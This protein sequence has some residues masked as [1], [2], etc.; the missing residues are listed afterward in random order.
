LLLYLPVAS[1]VTIDGHI[2]PQEWAQARHITEFRK[3]VPL[4]GEAPSLATEAW[5]LATPEGL[6][7]AFHS[8]QPLSIPRTNQRVQRDF[9]AQVDRVNVFVDFEG[10]HR[11]AYEFTIS[12][13]NGVS[14]GVI[15]NEYYFNADW[16][17]NWLHATS[18]DEFGWTAEVLLP[19][20]LAPMRDAQEGKR[21]IGLCLDRVVAATGER[22]AW[23]FASFERSRFISDFAPIE[24]PGFSQSLLAVTPY[25]SN[26]YDN[27]RKDGKTE[28]GG[29]LFWKPNGQ[30]QL[31]ATLNPD[32]GQVESDDLIVNFDATET[33]ISDKRPFFTENQSIFEFTTPA[34]YSQLLYTRRIGGPADD[35]NGS[36]DITA[37][38]K[39]NGNLGAT[40]YGVFAA[41]EAGDAG[42]TFGALRLVRDFS[43]QNLGFMLTEV[44]RPYFDREATV[45]GVDQNWRPTSKWNVRTRVIGS[46][47]EQ[48]DQSYS[49]LGETMLVDYEMNDGWR[50]QWMAIHFGK[51]LEIND[52]GYLAR[53]SENYLHWQVNRRFTDLPESSRYSSKDWG[54]RISTDYNDRGE[55][56]SDQIRITRES[57]LRNGAYEY[58]NLRIHSNGVDDLLTR[59]HGSVKLPSYTTTYLEYDRPRKGN[60]LYALQAEAYGGG[61]SGNHRAGFRIEVEPTYFISD[62]FNVYVGVDASRKPDWLVWQQDNFIGSFDAREFQFN[63][64]FNWSITPAQE[65]RLKLQAIGLDAEARQGYRVDSRGNPIKSDE[66]LEDFSV[67]NLG[68]Q[69][70]YRFE[71]APLSYLYVVYGRGGYDQ[72]QST[73]NAGT[74]LNDS[75]RL[76]DDDQLLIKLSYRFEP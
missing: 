27:V 25:L 70:R 17:G 59:G 47:I 68:V 73:E 52:V 49:D 39:L 11:T 40:K 5:V 51:E 7:V 15:T 43:N 38:L 35:G 3:V 76:R 21:I 69:L 31:A 32:F 62:A 20:H 12:S 23:P 66:L 72:Q 16:D 74:L 36:G 29:D 55:R 45:A 19:W 64:G 2:E 44:K 10:D 46:D 24:V 48:Q 54:L 9:D 60:W 37:A 30:I 4:N 22:V 61:L 50:Q 13:T 26:L 41:D 57:R 18:Q 65:L 71:L 63:A 53:N 1:A 28:A 67:R 56:L 14:D 6:A 75:F 33:F 42:R 34:D 58:A 8:A